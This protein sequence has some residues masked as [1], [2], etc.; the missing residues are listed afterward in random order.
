MGTPEN[1]FHPYFTDK[2]TEGQGCSRSHNW[3]DSTTIAPL[4]PSM[5]PFD[6]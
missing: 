1:Y 4:T 5:L 2:E 6:R 3:Q